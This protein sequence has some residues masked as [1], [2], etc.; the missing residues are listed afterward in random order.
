MTDQICFFAFSVVK[1]ADYNNYIQRIRS[2]F[3][4]KLMIKITCKACTI[5]YT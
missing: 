5:Q 1:I 2:R 4:K 3:Y